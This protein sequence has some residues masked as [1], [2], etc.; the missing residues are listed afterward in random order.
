MPSSK[1]S[2][3]SEK[4]KVKTIDC[5]IEK[6]LQAQMSSKDEPSLYE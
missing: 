1:V 2:K 4:Q 3:K 5:Q 6:S